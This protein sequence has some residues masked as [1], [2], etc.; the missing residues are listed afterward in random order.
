MNVATHAIINGKSVHECVCRQLAAFHRVRTFCMSRLLLNDSDD[1]SVQAFLMNSWRSLVLSL[2]ALLLV[3][4][5]V[6]PPYYYEHPDPMTPL[7]W[8]YPVEPYPP[9]DLYYHDR[10]HHPDRRHYFDEPRYPDQLPGTYPSDPVEERQISPPSSIDV[11]GPEKGSEPRVDTKDVPTA[12]K[13]SKPGRV[14]VPFPPYNELDVSGLP[15]GSLAKDP[16]T[17]KVFRLP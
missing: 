17:G 13:G 15:S 8:I 4:G 16:T 11:P 7:P 3:A 6:Y 9:R 10:R 12:T 1:W 14:K 5:C 2:L